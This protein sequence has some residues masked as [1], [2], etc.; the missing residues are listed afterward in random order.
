MLGHLTFEA[1]LRQRRFEPLA[2]DRLFVGVFD[3]RPA[4]FTIEGTLIARPYTLILFTAEGAERQIPRRFGSRVEVLMPPIF[5]RHHHAAFVPFVF[6]DRRA[7]GP[8]ERVTFAAEDDHVRAGAV[9][10][11]LFVSAD[12]EFRD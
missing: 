11:R 10:V 12:R 2:H 3:L 5:R 4:L 8:D 7:V 6:F 9:P 1:A